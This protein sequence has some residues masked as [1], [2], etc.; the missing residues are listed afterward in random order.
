MSFAIRTFAHTVLI[1]SHVCEP[2]WCLFQ[3]WNAHA[4]QAISPKVQT[5][6]VCSWTRL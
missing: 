5:G 6:R 2:L 4:S 3:M 1:H